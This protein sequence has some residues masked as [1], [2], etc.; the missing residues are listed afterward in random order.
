MAFDPTGAPQFGLQDVKIATWTATNTYG[1][2]VDVPAAQAFS[3][4]LRVVNAELTGDDR[5]M[6]TATRVIGSQFTL[7][8]GSVSLAVLEVLLGLTATSSIA[9]PNNVKILEIPGGTRFPYFGLVA[10]AYAEEGVGQFEVFIPKAKIMGD[11]QLAALE[12]GTFSTTEFTVMAVDD[13]TYGVACLIEAEATRAL[14]I[15]PADI[16]A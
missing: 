8:F 10:M 2:E 7:R 13:A 9:T 4:V 12:Y 11:L 5:I 1:T 14:T 15:P 3:N 16:P 6:A